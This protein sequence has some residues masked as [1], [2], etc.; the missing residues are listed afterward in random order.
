MNED[1]EKKPF[2]EWVKESINYQRIIEIKFPAK[3]YER[4]RNLSIQEANGCYWLLVERMMDS[5]ENKEDDKS[6]LVL[7][8][9]LSKRVTDVE[10]QVNE[11]SSKPK[12]EIKE[13]KSF[14]MK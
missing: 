4:F 12:E 8:K 1:K 7:Y 11:L 3:V 6:S 9:Q 14:G 13:R 2:G 10:L 5:F